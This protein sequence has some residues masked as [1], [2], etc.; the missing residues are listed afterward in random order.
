MHEMARARTLV[1]KAA[2]AIILTGLIGL[3]A[4]AAS[5][6]AAGDANGRRIF[7]NVC[8]ACHQDDGKGMPG[9]FPPLAGSDYLQ[10]DPRRAIAIV[11]HGLR[12]DIVVDGDHYNG[13]MPPEGANLT[14]QD[15]ADVLT[16]VLTHFGNTGGAVTAAE[17]AATRRAGGQGQTPSP[18]TK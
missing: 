15:I 12:G 10:H 1:L 18:H 17:V 9:V 11:L 3:Q 6:P 2:C 13:V 5:P 8:A 16:H 14:D 4:V 7:D